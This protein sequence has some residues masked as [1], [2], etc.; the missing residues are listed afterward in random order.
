MK[1]DEN[2]S[3]FY[4]KERK[5]CRVN[6]NNKSINNCSFKKNKIKNAV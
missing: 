3:V 2:K 6:D 5:E 4:I 1:Q